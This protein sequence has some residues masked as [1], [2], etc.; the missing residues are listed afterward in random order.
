MA[1]SGD[2]AEEAPPAEEPNP[3]SPPSLPTGLPTF[4]ASRP[5]AARGDGGPQSIGRELGPG[6]QRSLRAVGPGAQGDPVRV[7]R[8][9]HGNGGEDD[10]DAGARIDQG[11]G[12][13][14][15]GTGTGPGAHRTAP[16]FL[17]CP[18]N[19]GFASR[20]PRPC[21][22]RFTRWAATSAFFGLRVS[23]HHWPV[24]ATMPTSAWA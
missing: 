10:A 5:S 23:T 20:L 16:Q 12:T 15:A 18:I 6:D 4:T 22:A 21:Q 8:A 1:P 11:S 19:R 14:G 13:A 24:S 17:R 7:G 2:E 9:S 3:R